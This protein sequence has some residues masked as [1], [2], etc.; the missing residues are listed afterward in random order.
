MFRFGTL[1]TGET[2]RLSPRTT[3]GDAVYS[4][5]FHRCVP[6]TGVESVDMDSLSPV[7][8]ASWWVR[9]YFN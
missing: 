9:V 2:V 1:E 4:E 8:Q 6:V 3:V 7:E 5:K